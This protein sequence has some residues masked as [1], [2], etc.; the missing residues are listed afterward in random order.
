MSKYQCEMFGQLNY[1]DILTYEELQ[2][3]EGLLI[4]RLDD[5]LQ[6]AGAAHVDF[7]PTGD[8]LLTQ[9]VFEAYKLYIFRKL[10]Q[11]LAGLLPEAVRG[12]LFFLQK[13][14]LVQ[15]TY[16][17]SAGSWQEEERRLPQDA[18]AHLPRH[19]VASAPIWPLPAPPE[20]ADDA[21]PAAA[22]PQPA[23]AGPEDAQA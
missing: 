20:Q 6:Q 11:E 8:V 2:E 16:W 21:V 13:D 17:L 9:C 15:H 5:L 3:V 7:T 10:A 22:P 18:P 12:N 14:L 23:P 19:A 4:P 1:G